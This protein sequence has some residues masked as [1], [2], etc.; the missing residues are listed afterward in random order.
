MVKFSYDP[1]SQFNGVKLFGESQ[2]YSPLKNPTGAAATAQAES[3]KRATKLAKMIC[4]VRKKGSLAIY[5]QP[6]LQKG[7][8]VPFL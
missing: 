1:F 7:T 5:F 8:H 6:M 3:A 2:V 4:R